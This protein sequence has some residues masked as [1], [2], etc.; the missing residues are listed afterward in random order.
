MNR[1]SKVPLYHQVALLLR[2]EIAEGAFRIGDQIP[3]ERDLMERFQVSRITIR[4]AIDTLAQEGIVVRVQ[5]RGTFV[6][7]VPARSAV[8]ELA[9]ALETIESLGRET[10][11]QLIAAAFVPPPRSIRDVFGLAPSREVLKVSRIRSVDRE[12]FAYLTN[13]MAHPWAHQIQLDQLKQRSLLAQLKDLDGA[14]D[15]AEQT[16]S[17]TLAVPEVA[18]HLGIPAGS[19]LLKG[20][21]VYYRQ[22]RPV[23]VLDSLYRPDRYAYRVRLST[24]EPQLA[25]ILWEAEES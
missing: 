15:S 14:P 2:T 12:P 5:G 4:Q 3:P 8:T 13:W 1:F 25:G 10:Q 7:N 11:V 24:H 19:P 23:M 16:I 18:A 22:G 21:R 6:K 20:Y 9:G 17:A